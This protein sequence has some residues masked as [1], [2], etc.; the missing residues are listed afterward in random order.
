MC[1]VHPSAGLTSVVIEWWASLE[2]CEVSVEE[3]I[4][5]TWYYSAEW[6][7]GILIENGQLHESYHLGPVL[8]WFGWSYCM[9]STDGDQQG[10]YNEMASVKIRFM[11]ICCCQLDICACVYIILPHTRLLQVSRALLSAQKR[12]VCAN[13]LLS[14]SCRL[15]S[16]GI[17]EKC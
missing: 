16:P 12:K 10:C 15:P 1:Y 17:S 8:S 4:K 13:V 9:T 2:S 14:L 11:C 5:K 3:S 7:W 6:Q